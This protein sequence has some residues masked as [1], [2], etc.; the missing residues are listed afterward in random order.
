MLFRCPYATQVW[1]ALG[2]TPNQ[3]TNMAQALMATEHNHLVQDDTEVP[4]ILIAI[5]WNIWLARNMKV[6]D[7][8]TTPCSAI[9]ENVVQTL[10]LWKHRTRKEPRSLA[11]KAWT[12]IWEQPAARTSGPSNLEFKDTQDVVQ[13][14]SIYFSSASSFSCTL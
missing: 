11:I 1:T 14:S 8:V 10:Q 7:N 13:F 6:L 2:F 5:A 3:H 4:T 9:K 12:Q